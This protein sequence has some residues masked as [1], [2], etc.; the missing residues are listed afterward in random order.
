MHEFKR[1]IFI[2]LLVKYPHLRKPFQHYLAKK[3]SE[4]ALIRANRVEKSLKISKRT[5]SSTR[6][7]RVEKNTFICSK[8]S[9]KTGFMNLS[10]KKN[11]KTYG[12]IALKFHLQNHFWFEMSPPI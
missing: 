7:L 8:K 4:Q 10:V 6:D 1:T 3:L 5:S 2:V 11:F 9:S 12:Y